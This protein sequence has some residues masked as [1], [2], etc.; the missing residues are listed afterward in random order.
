MSSL[1]RS[2]PRRTTVASL[3]WF[4]HRAVVTAER[5]EG[6]GRAARSDRPADVLP[7]SDEQFVDVEP[8]LLRHGP[9]QALLRRLRCLRPNE[10]QA[11]ADSMHMGVRRDSRLSESVHEYAVRG[12]RPDLGKPD[13]LLVG[14]GDHSPKLLEEHPAHLLDLERFLAVEADRFDQALEIRAVRV[15]DGLRGIVLREQLLRRPL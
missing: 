14:P 10:A 4:H 13:E 1:N 11:V 12:L 8:V 3:F 6:T 5:R 2:R 15:S 9:H 7:E